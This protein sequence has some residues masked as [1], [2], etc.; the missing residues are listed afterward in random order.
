MRGSAPFFVNNV[1]LQTY[2][3]ITVFTL[4]HFLDN[5]AVAVYS[6]ASRLTGTLLFFPTALGIALLPSLT[7]LAE[8]NPE[9]IRGVQ[10][11]VFSLL[12]IL[13]VPTMLLTIGLAYPLCHLIYG[14]TKWASVP[15]TLQIY[16]VALLPLYIVSTMYQFLIAKGKNGIWVWFLIASIGVNVAC[17]WVLIPWTQAH[18]H[19]GVIGAA[20]STVIAESLS[21][22]CAIWLLGEGIFTRES[23]GRLL[24][25]MVAGWTDG[26]NPL[27][28]A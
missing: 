15:G 9:Q 1:I 28:N 21:A 18:L 25:T 11:R 4:K 8:G 23:V 12:I 10:A 19:N 14:N 16:A 2:G 20:I 26:G 22:V 24:R 17:N 27:L 5:G 3:A 13:G 7:R 6:Q